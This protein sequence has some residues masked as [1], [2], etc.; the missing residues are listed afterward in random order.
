MLVKRVFMEINLVVEASRFMVLGMVA[1]FLFLILLVI[2]LNIQATV[3]SK[4]FP[5]KAP[6]PAKNRS[7]S[8]A[9][10]A[11]SNN[12]LALIAAITA[13]VTAHRKSKK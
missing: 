11:K 4:F 8:S 1:V 12:N 13:A 5:P 9:H 6:I 10:V 3:I 7:Q 2:V